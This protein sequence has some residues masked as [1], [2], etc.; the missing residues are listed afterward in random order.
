M[1]KYD[2]ILDD[3]FIE[4]PVKF[5]AYSIVWYKLVSRRDADY[6]RC[7]RYLVLEAYRTEPVFADPML[8]NGGNL[9][10]DHPLIPRSDDV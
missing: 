1:F 9:K 8:M 7:L 3:I 2:P 10:H 4:R 6:I 5:P